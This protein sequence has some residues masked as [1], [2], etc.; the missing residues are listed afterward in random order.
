MAA[1]DGK[2]HHICFTWTNS[3][4]SWQLY[5]DGKLSYKDTGLK[6]GYTIKGNGILIV[7]QDQDLLNNRCG[8]NFDYKQS[9]QGYMTNLNLWSNVLS[10]ET[11]Q[12]MSKTCS[13]E[14]GNVLKWSDF[15]Q[16]LQG[17]TEVVVPS[18]CVP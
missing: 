14:E 9:F 12:E 7:G 4:G 10:S 6:T 13:S 8:G 1:N 16:T 17:D 15:K 5:K 3:D 18:P 2:W 11:I